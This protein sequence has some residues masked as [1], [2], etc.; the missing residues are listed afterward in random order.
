MKGLKNLADP[1]KS[2]GTAAKSVHA[3]TPSDAGNLEANCD[4]SGSLCSLLLSRSGCGEND[5]VL[6]LEFGLLEI[7]VNALFNQLET[8]ALNKP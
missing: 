8:F 1:R 6:L 7:G 4:I 5:V 2:T 3:S